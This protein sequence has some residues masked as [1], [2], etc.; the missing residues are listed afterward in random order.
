MFLFLFQILP[1]RGSSETPSYGAQVLQG[2]L[3]DSDF[4]N[5]IQKSSRSSDLNQSNG[6]KRQFFTCEYDNCN[7]STHNRQRLNMHQKGHTGTPLFY[8][9]IEGCGY[10]SNFKG[11]IKIHKRHKH[12]E[13]YDNNGSSPNKSRGRKRKFENL[14]FSDSAERA[15]EQLNDATL[16]SSSNDSKKD[17]DDL[18]ICQFDSNSGNYTCQWPNCGW[19]TRWKQLIEPHI[20]GHTGMKPYKC[21][22][23]GCDYQTN[24]KGNVKL[25]KKKHIKEGI[26]GSSGH[27]ADD[28][29]GAFKCDIKGCDFQTVWK[30]SYESHIRNHSKSIPP[31]L[32]SSRTSENSHRL[33]FPR[34]GEKTPTR[35]SITM[36]PMIC[37]ESNGIEKKHNHG[38]LS[39]SEPDETS[40]KEQMSLQ[41]GPSNEY[42]MSSSHS[43]SPEMDDDDDDEEPEFIGQTY[44]DKSSARPFLVNNS[45]Y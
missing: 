36:K 17:K 7:Y 38:E 1:T 4:V 19:T 32:S 15:N 8:C 16:E 21:D 29:V 12:K 6:D 13:G 3:N 35:L 40:L 27:G 45:H 23:P 33:V 44:M 10:L 22:V 42:K 2:F 18:N 25:H 43:N 34:P 31:T 20:L 41:D 24:Y 28:D 11:N 14:H 37:K 9:D 5:N 39:S 30:N 26:Y